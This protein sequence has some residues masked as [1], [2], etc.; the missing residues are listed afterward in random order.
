M[1]MPSFSIFSLS[2]CQFESETPLFPG[3]HYRLLLQNRIDTKPV[4]ITRATVIWGTHTNYGLRFID[5][6]PAEELGIKEILSHMP[7]TNK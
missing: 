3:L 1:A 7:L 4:T 5:T 2:G 6:A